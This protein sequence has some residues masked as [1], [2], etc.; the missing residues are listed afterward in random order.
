[1]IKKF[2]LIAMFAV[3]CLGCSVSAPAQDGFP[4][5]VPGE[6]G[7]AFMVMVNSKEDAPLKE[8]ITKLMSPNPDLTLDQRVERFRGIR[9]DFEG[10]KLVK[11]VNSDATGIAF[12]IETAKG[13]GFT[14]RLELEETAEKRIDG[15][16]AEPLK[17]DGAAETPKASALPD[18]K[19]MPTV[20]AHIDKLAAEG[21][22]SGVVLIAKGGKPILS[23]AVG[24]ADRDLKI[25]NKVDTKFNIGSEN[26]IFT[27]LAIGMLADDGKLS[28]DD[29]LGKF[30]PAYPNKQAAEKVTIRHLL[31]MSSGIGDFFG[32]AFDAHPKEKVRG[33]N[34][35]LQ[36]FAAKPL[37]FEP[38]T[39]RQYSNGGFVVL[40]AIVE[41]VSG[42]TYYEFVRNRIFKPVGMENTDSYES[43]ARVP[44][45]AMGYFR[46]EKTNSLMKNL[47]T[48]PAKGSSAGGGY[49][50][51]E[52]MLKFAKAIESG[53]I[54]PKSIINAKDPMIGGMFQGI[55]IAGGAPGINAT[56]DTKLPGGF[57]VIVMSNF[58]PPSAEN[59]ARQIRSWLGADD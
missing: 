17:K 53:K 7:R 37:E 47:S 23:K 22:F 58:D 50:T 29:A 9:K 25:A 43:D 24:L 59:V 28:F 8:F 15:I 2:C 51:A 34:D 31:T 6:R 27:L 14:I 57:T 48:R 21:S 54:V 49:S 18:D 13:D 38:G 46:D 42:Q 19:L 4:A 5:T 30:L 45:L 12:V 56:L 20:Q 35:F 39:K 32:P 40:G 41:K 33:I 44:N 3:F 55:G 1:M 26:K 52:D 10:A 16:A 36:F 11:V